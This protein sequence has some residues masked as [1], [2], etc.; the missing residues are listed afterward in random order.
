M[1]WASVIGDNSGYQRLPRGAPLPAVENRKSCLVCADL[2]PSFCP[3]FGTEVCAAA[4]LQPEGLYSAVSVAPPHGDD[5]LRIARLE[6][7]DVMVLGTR[8]TDSASDA[9]EIDEGEETWIANF[10]I[11]P[12]PKIQIEPSG[13]R[14][15]SHSG[16]IH[17]RIALDVRPLE[18]AQMSADAVAD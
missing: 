14:A 1:A 5:S 9:P 10:P 12:D 16:Y 13:G 8:A 15:A 17:G 18:R 4:L 2:L 6:I 3:G 11:E 7:H